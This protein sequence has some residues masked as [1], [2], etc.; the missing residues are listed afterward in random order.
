[1]LKVERS[2][3]YLTKEKISSE[4][5][6][7]V[8]RAKQIASRRKALRFKRSDDNP[9]LPENFKVGQA[10]GGG[11]CF[12][13]SVA[14]GLKQL[15]PDMDFTVKSLRKICKD[16]AVGNQQ[17]KSKIVKDA[18][19]RH[20]PTTVIPD[21]SISDDE[22]WN[23]YLA[24]IEYTNDDINKMR[25][26]NPSLYQSLTSLKYG[27]TLQAPIWG[28]PDIEGQMIC[29]KYNV[30]LHLIEKSTVA[31]VWLHQVIDETG[32]KSVGNVDYNDINTIH[33][34]NEGKAHFK[35][36][37]DTQR[38][39]HKRQSPDP[40]DYDDEITPEEE[41]INII[42]SRD[43]EE[44]KLAKIKR[45]F[46]KEPKPDINFQGK[47]NDTPLHIVVRKKELKVI[48]WLVKNGA[49]ID[50]KN[51]RGRTQ[52]EVAQHLDRQDIVQILESHIQLSQQASVEQPSTQQKRTRDDS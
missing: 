49:K 11:D 35:P 4:A 22:L 24:S 10:I 3:D 28:R 8:Q 15:K 14:K 31:A 37:L 52:L 5:S 34:V 16:L 9:E 2:I 44:E 33:I 29:K 45:L 42:K 46:E 40:S 7:E 41:L 13:D 48:E 19:N 27:N 32:S 26:D 21:N 51:S 6:E 18:R 17:L 30:K 43:S 36:I 38:I 50:V 39:Q 47:D 1:M 25:D 20:D 12:F 23:A